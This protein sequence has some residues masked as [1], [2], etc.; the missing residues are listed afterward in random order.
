MVSCFEFLR[1]YFSILLR[2]CH[3]GLD[4]SLCQI[5]ISGGMSIVPI[6]PCP[7]LIVHDWSPRQLYMSLVCPSSLPLTSHP[8]MSV[9]LSATPSVSYIPLPSFRNNTNN[10][11]T[12]S[13]HPL[14]L[15]RQRQPPP[16]LHPQWLIPQRPLLLPLF[17]SLCDHPHF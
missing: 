13:Y 16:P 17:H 1:I 5:Y 3:I 10:N 9:A 14:I 2:L 15:P 8:T 7:F 12:I 4:C 6:L 11:L